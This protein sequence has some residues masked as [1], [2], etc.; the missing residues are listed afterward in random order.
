[1][2]RIKLQDNLMDVVTKMSDGNPGAITTLMQMLQPTAQV[3][4]PDS[5][6]GTLG[7]IMN[8]DTLEVYGI[9]IYILWNDV[10]NRD[11][12]K[13]FTVLRAQQLGFI[14]AELIREISADQNR[15]KLDKIDIEAL[16]AKVKKE[17][18]NFAELCE[19]ET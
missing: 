12:V 7:K 17:L 2:S 1:M 3:I 6:M 13:M 10:C 4:D 9:D 15:S 14:S 11:M 5:I 16:H 19:Q 8:L 18:P